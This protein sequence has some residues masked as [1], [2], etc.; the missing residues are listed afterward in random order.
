MQLDSQQEEAV[1]TNSPR[2]LV[3]AA[4]GSGKTRVLTERI[5]HLIETQHVSPYEILAFTFTRKA[6][7]EMKDRL[8]KRI[9]PKA[10]HCTLGTMHAVALGYLRRFGEVL[11]LRTDNIT[12]Y[13]QFEE[14]YLLKE[15]ALEIGFVRISGTRSWKIPKRDIDWVF[16]NY[17]EL[18]FP[19]L[20]PNPAKPLFDAF[21]TRCRENNALTYGGLLIA[22]RDLIPTLAKHLHIKHLLVDEVQ[23]IDPLQWSIINGMCEAFG[24]SLFA[25]GD[26]QQS[27]YSFRG[28]VPKYL[29]EH[30]SDFD[31][32]HLSTNYRSVPE[33][34]EP[35]NRLISHNTERIGGVMRANRE[36]RGSVTLKINADSGGLASFFQGA[37]V[38]E[39]WAKSTAVLSRIHAL[40]SKLSTELTARDIPHTYI[41]KKSSIV[42]SEEFVRFHSFLKLIVNP[43]D[44][45]SF[46]LIKDLISLSAE[47]Y[48]EIRVRGARDGLS[49]F[50][51]W[52]ADDK[53]SENWTHFF[54]GAMNLSPRDASIDVP[55]QLGEEYKATFD[56]IDEWASRNPTG[57]IKQ[58]LDWLATYDLQDEMTDDQQG[59][60]LMTIH[61]AKGLEWPTVIII[62]AN[63]GILPSKQ[64]IKT[65]EI[66]EERRLAYV[67]MTRAKDH[68]ILAARPER[69]EKDGRVFESPQS[70]FIQEA[71]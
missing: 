31:I 51:A 40:L 52:M 8:A 63:E 53:A 47:D 69:T 22:L 46:L 54:R 37:V 6:A 62:G 42:H 34:V 23:D 7:G 19:P 11:G 71:I 32:H 14:E 43:H 50:E 16:R 55:A 18:G 48:S 15:V 10:H 28:A 9:G 26:V 29:I 20:H 41:G 36:D 35:A 3:S 44:N 65:G 49:H 68:L 58:Y 25:V 45:F 30:Q 21:Q 70:R 24:A 39:D 2:V 66:E 1:K 61:A 13:S 12:V 56:F 64:A 59:L 4:A 5:A 57:T 67:A 17:Y 38:A 60:V 27:I 33:I